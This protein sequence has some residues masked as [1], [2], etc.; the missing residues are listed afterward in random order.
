[1]QFESA[2]RPTFPMPT[3]TRREGIQRE[4]F[5]LRDLMLNDR[6][7]RPHFVDVG[8]LRRTAYPSKGLQWT[9]HCS[10]APLSPSEQ[11]RK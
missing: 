2:S 4:R 9:R 8:A 11:L 5:G 6:S 3:R 10:T 1:M 7:V